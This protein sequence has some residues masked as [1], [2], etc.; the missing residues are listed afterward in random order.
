MAE[1]E[2]AAL[3]ADYFGGG[4]LVDAIGTGVALLEA[5]QLLELAQLPLKAHV[6]KNHGTALARELESLLKLHVF[7]LHEVGND[8][9]GTATHASVAVDQ[10]STLGHALLYE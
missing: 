6:G 4:D 8:T 2:A 1:C 7:L 10:D 3:T 9:A 5:E